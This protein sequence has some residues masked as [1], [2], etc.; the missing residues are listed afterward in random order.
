VQLLSSEKIV[1]G[2]L[3]GFHRTQDTYEGRVLNA[4][5]NNVQGNRREV[6]A[7]VRALI[8][9][10]KTLWIDEA[11]RARDQL[12]HPVKGIHRLMFQLDLAVQGDGFV[13]ERINPPIIGARTIDDYAWSTLTQADSFSS[14]FLRQLK[15]S[16][17]SNSCMELAC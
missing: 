14:N 8:V 1:T 11:I 6:A 12:I 16:A 7:K 10:H 15:E 17:V 4:L 9:E 3:D 13:C 5:D 2:V